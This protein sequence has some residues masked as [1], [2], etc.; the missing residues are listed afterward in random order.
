M[1]APVL[2]TQGLDELDDLR[3]SLRSAGVDVELDVDP[4]TATLPSAVATTGY[5]IVQEALT[6]VVRH[7]RGSSARVRVA[8]EGDRV[9]IDVTDDGTGAVG[10]APG[11]AVPGGTGNGVRGMRERAQAA[12]GT[13]EAGPRTEGGWRVRATLPV[14]APVDAA[15]STS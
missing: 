5:R 6:N 8:R 11:A 9:V 10:P 7:A 1:Q 4:A 15:V 3:A 13:L 12:G 14:P 2:P